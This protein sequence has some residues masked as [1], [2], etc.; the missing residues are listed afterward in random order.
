MVV[1]V[2]VKISVEAEWVQGGE[3]ERDGEEGQ[4]GVELLGPT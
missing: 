2:V 3:D 1:D 4:D